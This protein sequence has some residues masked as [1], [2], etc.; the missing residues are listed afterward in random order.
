MIMMKDA[1][2]GQLPWM[3]QFRGLRAAE[4]QFGLNDIPKET[5]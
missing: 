1:V 5:D 3:P 2:R 4:L